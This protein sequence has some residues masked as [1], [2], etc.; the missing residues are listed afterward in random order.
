MMTQKSKTT[1]SVRINGD[2]LAQ[3]ETVSKRTGQSLNSTI[4]HLLD[5][6]ANWHMRAAAAGFM[7]FPRM[8]VSDL[9]CKLTEQEIR[10]SAQKYISEELKDAI[11]LL[12]K[13]ANFEDTRE[14]FGLWM[15]ISGFTYRS[16][17]IADN[18]IL[19]L[20]LRLGKNASL[21]MAEIF[22]LFLRHLGAKNVQYDFT[23]NAV[24]LRYEEKENTGSGGVWRPE[25]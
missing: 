23:A 3:L 6:E 19:I 10:E 11:L 5:Q 4:N 21:L 24:I 14:V 8:L 20:G 18:Y 17:H 7:Y 15:S 12:R 2:T 22:S 1:F 9:T 13:K 16:E 25:N